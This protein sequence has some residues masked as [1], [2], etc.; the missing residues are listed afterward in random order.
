MKPAGDY[1][2]SFFSTAG[3]LIPA[4]LLFLPRKIILPTYHT[5]SDHPLPHIKH[6]HTV[7]TPHEFIRDL[8]FILKHFEPVDAYRLTEIVHRK[9]KITKNY[10]HLSFDDAL[11]ECSEIIAPI[12]KSKGIP[13]TFFINPYFIDNK[14]LM[15]RYKVSVMIE[16]IKNDD[17]KRKKVVSFIK[18]KLGIRREAISFLLTLRYL[19]KRF[20]DELAYLTGTDFDRFLQEQKPYLTTAQIKTMQ[21]DGFTIGAHSLNHPEYFMISEDEQLRQTIESIKYIEEEFSISYKLFAFPFTDHHVS[22]DFFDKIFLSSPPHADLTFGVAGLKRDTH[23]HHLQR[24]P[25]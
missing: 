17:E 5:V 4:N 1:L 15:H 21:S 14:D 11:R 9:E 12:L 7:K 10:F 3:N 8:D 24:I 19:H 23:P 25:M 18:K 6:L 20:T 16:S 22:K 2:R 13:A